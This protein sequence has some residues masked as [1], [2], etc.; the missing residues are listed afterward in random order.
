MKIKNKKKKWRPDPWPIINDTNLL[1]AGITQLYACDSR[2]KPQQWKA[3]CQ[4]RGINPRTRAHTMS[5]KASAKQK[6]Q[7]RS[8]ADVN[9]TQYSIE[10]WDKLRLGRRE[11]VFDN[12]LWVEE[13]WECMSTWW[14]QAVWPRVHCTKDNRLATLPTIRFAYLV[15]LLTKLRWLYARPQVDEMTQKLRY[16][17]LHIPRR[18]KG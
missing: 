8:E 6:Q 4:P 13:T 10:P 15:R 16:T 9:G 2:R 12:K 17:V 3:H 1:W 14:E 11:F 18:T 5:E 7:L